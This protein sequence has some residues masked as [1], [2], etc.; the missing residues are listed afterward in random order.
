MSDAGILVGATA[1]VGSDTKEGLFNWKDAQKVQSVIRDEFGLVQ[2]TA[3]PAWGVWTG[4]AQN[5]KV[6]DFTDMNKVIDWAQSNNKKT[7]IHLIAGSGTYFPEWFNTGNW[8][9]AQVEEQFNSWITAVVTSNGNSTK[10]DYWNVVNEAFT[11]DGNYWP[12][13]TQCRWQQLG[14]ED[15]KSGLSGSAKVYARHPVYIR[16]A[17]EKTRALTSAKLELRDYYIEFWDDSKKARAFYQLVKHLK[18]TG[19]PIDAVGFQGH[20]RLD[21]TYDWSKL[22]RAVREYKTLGL[23]VYITELDYGDDDQIAPAKASQWTPQLDEAQSTG[24]YDLVKASVSAGVDWICLWGVADNTNQYWRMGQ[25]ALLFNEQYQPKKA[26]ES[27]KQGI[28]DGKE[29]VGTVNHLKLS[30]RKRSREMSAYAEKMKVY[31]ISGKCIGTVSANT[32]GSV[33]GRLSHGVY[34]LKP[35]AYESRPGKRT[36]TDY[37]FV[38]Q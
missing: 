27:F 9:T 3:Y 12:D 31:T 10:V 30:G 38:H 26:Y 17:F 2:T 1:E 37:M 36:V 35:M 21:K 18:N 19:A 34:L 25:H 32:I 33:T 13:S 29:A 23:E 7:C 20:F 4:N 6:F 14:W 5:P 8:T 22:N 28:V 11:W 15:D 24:Y 16:K